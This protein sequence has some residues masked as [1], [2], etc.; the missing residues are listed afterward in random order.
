MKIFLVYHD[1]KLS[2]FKKVFPGGDCFKPLL[3]GAHKYPDFFNTLRD[4]VFDNISKKNDRFC[5]L[6]GFYWMWKNLDL[7]DDDYVGLMHYRR[8]LCFDEWNRSK[9][10]FYGM[11]KHDKFDSEYVEQCH[12]NKVSILYHLKDADCLIADDYD[13]TTVG[14]KNNYDLYKNGE[15]LNIE[16]YDKAINIL[17]RKHPEYA[18]FVEKFNKSKKGFYTNIF[19]SKFKFFKE[20]CEWL[21]PILFELE[22]QIDFSDY[23]AQETRVI[24]HIAERLFAIYLLAKESIIE[25]VSETIS[26]T[27]ET[28]QN[29]TIKERTVIYDKTLKVKKIKRT[30]IDHLDQ[31]DPED[32]IYDIP[33][34]QPQFHEKKAIVTIATNNYVYAVTSWLQSL[35]DNLHKNENHEIYI[36]EPDFTDKTKNNLLEQV[37]N[38]QNIHLGFINIKEISKVFQEG[39][40]HSHLL[41]VNYTR[42]FIPEIFK[43]YDHILYLDGDMIIVD[44]INDIFSTDF[45]G[46]ALAAVQ[47][48]IFEH[49][50]NIEVDAFSIIYHGTAEDYLQEYLGLDS[51]KD[52]LQ[53]GCLLFDIQT[54]RKG[55]FFEKMMVLFHLNNYWFLDQDILNV[56]F[57]GN[58]KFL[59]YAYNAVTANGRPGEFSRQI[60]DSDLLQRYEH[61]LNNPKIIHFCGDKK[62]WVDPKVIHGK[63]FYKY[64]QRTPY[65]HAIEH[66]RKLVRLKKMLKEINPKKLIKKSMIC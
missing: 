51:P 32:L 60:T 62:P 23:S 10:S 26:E 61:A 7:Q 57:K 47:D 56:A 44:D 63:E 9:A 13:V 21:F 40:T 3:I 27:F 17:L 30:F 25:R 33:Y 53:A 1:I 11:V 29:K 12:L 37:K 43:D 4:D 28:S 22:E 18:P 38:Y 49:F 45:E 8:H 46:N 16:D 66:N 54:I 20:Y 48:V 5:E 2:N 65:K 31:S 19:V 6:T 35:I 59:D 15:F 55:D 34:I 58:I 36:L 24:G 41:S 50:C 52:Y 64:A 39:F 42:F 14:A